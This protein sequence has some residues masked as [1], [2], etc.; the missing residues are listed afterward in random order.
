MNSEIR[1]WNIALSNC[2]ECWR[3][4]SGWNSFSI[5]SNS[6]IAFVSPETELSV[7]KTPV[8]FSSSR[9]FEK[10][11]RTVSS[12]PPQA[13]A[14]T[15]LP[16]L[17]ASTATIP[18]SSSPGKS[19]ARHPA[20]FW[21]SSASVTCPRNSTVG[22]AIRRRAPSHGPAPIIFNCLPSFVQAAIAKSNLL[23]STRRPIA[24]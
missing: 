5:D 24:I 19:N 7:K 3:M 13:F 17:W 18:K 21:R 4:I 15:G 9:W 2:K 10:T 14:I 20:R 8:G 1:R 6:S 12:A 22:P 16:K 11:P 23:Y